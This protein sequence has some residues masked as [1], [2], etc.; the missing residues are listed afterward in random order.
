MAEAPAQYDLN[1]C[2]GPKGH[3][4][5]C[6]TATSVRLKPCASGTI[7]DLERFLREV[8]ET[9]DT[10]PEGDG[11]TRLYAVYDANG[12]RGSDYSFCFEL[13][14]QEGKYT[15][16]PLDEDERRV[17][18]TF[19]ELWSTLKRL[20]T[21]RDYATARVRHSSLLQREIDLEFYAPPTLQSTALK[22]ALSLAIAAGAP[23]ERQIALRTAYYD[24][25]RPGRMKALNRD[26]SN[27]W[28][29]F[30]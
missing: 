5:Y 1:R 8:V 20:I 17:S 18:P 3:A 29:G 22:M 11:Y 26:S 25:L 19:D 16:R 7:D 13:G 4:G 10:A 15:L 21:R 27:E 2:Y 28:F 9:E 6:R 23:T 30:D 14:R 12:A 24:A